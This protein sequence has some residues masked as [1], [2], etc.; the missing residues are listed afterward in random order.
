MMAMTNLLQKFDQPPPEQLQGGTAHS[1]DA[2]RDLSRR[3]FLQSAALVGASAAIPAGVAVSPSS[4]AVSAQTPKMQSESASAPNPIVPNFQG[5][6]GGSETPSFQVPKRAMGSTGLQVSILGMG[7]YHLGTAAG[8][9]EVNNMV[10]KALDHGINFFDN[11]WEYHGGMSEERVGTALKGKRDR[12]ILM[13]KVC[14]HGRKK[15]L[16]MQMLEESLRRL[17]AD[18]LDVWQVHEVIYYN[19]PELA[20]QTDGVLEALAAAKQ[21]GKVRFVGFTGH[22]NPSIHLDMLARGFPFDTV[23]MPINPFD[24]S[25]RSFEREVLPVAVQKGMAVFGMKSMGGSGEPIVQGALTPTEALS[26]AM[27]VPGVSTTISG[28]DSMAVLDQNLQILSNFKP[29]DDQQM[30]ALRAH[31][32]NFNDGRYELFKS[33]VKY[34]GAIGRDQHHYPTPTEL[35]A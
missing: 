17:Q 27:S 13:T 11:A 6:Y 15:D 18:H 22:K 28:M 4:G 7:G 29:L 5:R 25:F 26:Y 32:R 20:S 8:Q 21:Q 24:P 23:Q 33:S 10:A 2:H 1:N 19:D 3:R 31:G 16:A 35:P 30:D 14:T 9:N 12:A 34:D